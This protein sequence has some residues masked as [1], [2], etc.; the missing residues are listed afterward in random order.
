MA[1][2]HNFEGWTTSEALTIAQA[3]VLDMMPDGAHGEI[4]EVSICRDCETMHVEA[5]VTLM[6]R[7][8]FLIVNLSAGDIEL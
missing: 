5:N 2:L 1:R 4:T 6:G 3:H 8:R 7:P